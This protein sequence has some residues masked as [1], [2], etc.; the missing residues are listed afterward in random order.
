MCVHM[1]VCVRVFHW[2]LTLLCPDTPDEYLQDTGGEERDGVRT[3][4]HLSKALLLLR[5]FV[6]VHQGRWA[7]RQ[8]ALSRQVTPEGCIALEL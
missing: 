5:V 4:R 2:T 8:S 1:S 3:V 6:C 7:G